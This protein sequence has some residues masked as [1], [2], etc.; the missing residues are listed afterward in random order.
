[1]AA[2]PPLHGSRAL[3]AEPLPFGCLG[4]AHTAIVEPLNGALETEPG[5]DW[6]RTSQATGSKS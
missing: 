5:E 3:G 2:A 6:V 1:M 4:Q